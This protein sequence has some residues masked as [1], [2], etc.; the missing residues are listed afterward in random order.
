[1]KPVVIIAVSVICSVVAVLGVLVAMDMYSVNQAQKAVAIELERQKVCDKLYD[2]TGSLQ[3]IELWGICL[4]YGIIE[5]V[6]SDVELCGNSLSDYAELCRSEKKLEAIRLIER[7][8]TLNQDFYK[9]ALTQKS[10]LQT[11][12]NEYKQNIEIEQEKQFRLKADLRNAA[13]GDKIIEIYNSC[14]TPSYKYHSISC[15]NLL[16][17]IA[18]VIC[19]K[20]G[21]N[22]PTCFT[23][24]QM[25][26]KADRDIR[27]MELDRDSE[28][29][30]DKWNAVVYTC[31]ITKGETF[32][33]NYSEMQQCVCRYFED[34][35]FGDKLGPWDKHCP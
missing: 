13:T 11:E 7:E 25:D 27:F 24:V 1:M 29:K 6:N 19:D 30:M 26:I 4:N 5:S 31:Q 35:Y 21:N 17:E 16:N 3:D 10:D 28:I 20:Y 12:R 9:L 32:D 33:T 22:D 15:V 23:K 8:I 34:G 2:N 14:D 18:N